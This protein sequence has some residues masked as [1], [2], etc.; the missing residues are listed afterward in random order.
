M[1]DEHPI[2]LTVSARLLERLGYEVEA[3]TNVQENIDAA[4]WQP[5]VLV[6]WI[7]R[8]QNRVASKQLV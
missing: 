4:V 3:A 2:K 8:G 1:A 6:S 5:Y 7:I